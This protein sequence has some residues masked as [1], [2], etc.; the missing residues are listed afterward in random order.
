MSFSRLLAV[1]LFLQYLSGCKTCDQA[2]NEYRRSVDKKRLFGAC[3][4]NYDCVTIKELPNFVFT[5]RGMSLYEQEKIDNLRED[6][7][8]ICLDETRNK[9]NYKDQNVKI[10]D[11][12]SEFKD[13]PSEP[14]CVDDQCILAYPGSCNLKTSTADRKI[15]ERHEKTLQAAYVLFKQEQY[16]KAYKLI[17]NKKM[18]SE[19]REQQL[20]LMG[21]CQFRLKDYPAAL[22][23]FQEAAKA[24]ATEL[25]ASFYAACSAIKTKKSNLINPYLDK[26]ASKSRLQK[27]TADDYARKLESNP[28]FAELK[29]DRHFQKVVKLLKDAAK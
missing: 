20:M 19:Q 13:R 23:W 27:K 16:A 1:V 8:R 6:A 25:D 10:S 9:V 28:C 17:E 14:C 3:T 21:L 18:K 26:V 15:I 7:R 12:P 29:T 24:E 2:W 4:L 11:R 22:K 5:T